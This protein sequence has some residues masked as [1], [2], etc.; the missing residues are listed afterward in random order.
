MIADKYIELNA[1]AGAAQQACKGTKGEIR[2]GNLERLNLARNQLNQFIGTCRWLYLDFVT[3][4][5]STWVRYYHKGGQPYGVAVLSLCK[6]R[7]F[8]ATALRHKSDRWNKYV[9]RA[10]A[11]DAIQKAVSGEGI[12]RAIEIDIS[13]PMGSRAC[14]GCWLRAI[15]DSM[16]D[17]AYSLYRSVVPSILGAK[18]R[19][20]QAELQSL[21]STQ[22]VM[23]NQILALADGNVS[24]TSA[25]SGAALV[26]LQTLAEKIKIRR[27]KPQQVCCQS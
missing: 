25:A 17:T 10:M 24:A 12:G 18:N 16:Q 20:M 23:E 22:T 27:S 26:T 6:G 14:S 11:T 15:P 2:D 19:E 7:L 1:A 13:S 5:P 3:A 8:I 9:G 4:N 21:Q